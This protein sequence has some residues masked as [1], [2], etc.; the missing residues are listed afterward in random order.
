MQRPDKSE[1][2]NTPPNVNAQMNDMSGHS[3]VST[4]SWIWI[5]VSIGVLLL[6]VG[7][8]WFYKRRK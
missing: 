1:Q 5:I 4:N 7:V 8:A 6:G 2:T 3:N